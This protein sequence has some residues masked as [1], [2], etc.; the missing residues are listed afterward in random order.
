LAAIASGNEAAFERLFRAWYPRLAEHAWRLLHERDLAEDAAQEVLLAL[1]QGRDRLPDAGALPGYLHRAVR[2][3][4]LNQLRSR[5]REVADPD[6]LMAPRV[7]P[8]APDRLEAQAL[9]QRLRSALEELPPRTREVFLLSRAQ[10]LTYA[11]IAEVLGISVKT[12]ETLM[13]RAIRSLR[14]ELKR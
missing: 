12:V 13:G 3:R 14:E 7:E 8:D 10:G 1:W 2:N 6:G 4:A 11:A 5:K 9:E